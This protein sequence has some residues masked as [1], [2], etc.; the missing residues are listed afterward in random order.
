MVSGTHLL[1]LKI[2]IFVTT[3]QFF[4]NLFRGWISEIRFSPCKFVHLSFRVYRSIFL[5]VNFMLWYVNTCL[6]PEWLTVYVDDL[7]FFHSFHVKFLNLNKN[8]LTKIYLKLKF[9]LELV[10]VKFITVISLS[11]PKSF[12]DIN[13]KA[14]S[15][16]NR[17]M[18]STCWDNWLNSLNLDFSNS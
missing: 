5:T 7:T 13:A 4:E 6:A 14:W 16:I 17:M 1:P 10:G 9:S 2:H 8:S 18:D 11:S 12:R 15:S 3:Y